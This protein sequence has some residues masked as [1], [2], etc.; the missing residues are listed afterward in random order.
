MDRYIYIYIY[1]IYRFIYIL[2]PTREEELYTSK[3][4][5]RLKF[6]ETKQCF[7]VKTL[8]ILYI[9]NKEKKKKK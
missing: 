5:K 7:L 1:I 8:F 2:Y 9:V 3:G 6:G 4:E